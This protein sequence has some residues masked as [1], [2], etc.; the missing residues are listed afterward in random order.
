MVGNGD[1]EVTEQTLKEQESKFK[2]E[3]GQWIQVERRV[4]NKFHEGVRGE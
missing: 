3:Y 2:G 1:G 4:L